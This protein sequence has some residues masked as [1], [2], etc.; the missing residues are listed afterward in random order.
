[1]KVAA[2][3]KI[4]D[5]LPDDYDIPV[6]TWLFEEKHPY[7]VSEDFHRFIEK[8]GE[9]DLNMADIYHELAILGDSQD[10]LGTHFINNLWVLIETLQKLDG[11]KGDGK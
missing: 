10:D 5:D 7:L 8:M 6:L 2:A 1:M 9:R 4:L 3:K 11:E